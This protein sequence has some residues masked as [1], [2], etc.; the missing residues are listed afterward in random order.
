MTVVTLEPLLDLAVL[1]GAKA[2]HRLR[3]SAL[4]E[5]RLYQAA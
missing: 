1:A 2:T 4:V 5:R 3:G